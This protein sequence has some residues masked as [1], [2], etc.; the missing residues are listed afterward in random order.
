MT[1]LIIGVALGAAGMYAKD[2]FLGNST[3]NELNT[4]KRELEEVYAE[5]EKFRKRN[6]DLSRQVEDLQIE[7]EKLKRRSNDMDD[8][9]YDLEDDLSKAKSEAKK[10]RAQNDELYM[11]LQEYKQACESYELEISRLKKQ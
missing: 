4:K 3:T 6:K 10:L 5:N 7:N 9:H 11:K 1:E 2:K 8:A